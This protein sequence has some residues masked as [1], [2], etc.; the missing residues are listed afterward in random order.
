MPDP[1]GPRTTTGL[2]RQLLQDLPEIVKGLAGR[3]PARPLGLFPLIQQ[4]RELHET[5]VQGVAL[6]RPVF[7]TFLVIAPQALHDLV[8]LSLLARRRRRRQLRR[9]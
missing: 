6:L 3:L 9:A 7:D 1:G 5:L 4:Q 2:F 8:R